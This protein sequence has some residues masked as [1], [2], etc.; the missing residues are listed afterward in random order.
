MIAADPWLQLVGLVVSFIGALFLGVAQQGAGEDAVIGTVDTRSGRPRQSSFVILHH[1]RLW[2]WGIVLLILGFA[3]QA[4]GV[5]LAWPK[6][7]P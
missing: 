5:F 4:V 1:P 7:G 2:W 6:G 3:L